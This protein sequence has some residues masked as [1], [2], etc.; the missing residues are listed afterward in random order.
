MKGC[1]FF[2][3]CCNF[4]NFLC[5]VSS[6]CFLRTLGLAVEEKV[7]SCGKNSDTLGEAWA[8]VVLHEPLERDGARVGDVDAVAAVEEEG[9]APASDVQVAP[10]DNAQRC[11]SACT[12]R[13]GSR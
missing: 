4:D 13:P 5:R 2:S 12:A 1:D 8:R 7:P 10:A 6:C 3:A 9:C 11:I